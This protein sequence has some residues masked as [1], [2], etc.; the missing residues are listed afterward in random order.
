MGTR[1]LGTLRRS[2]HAASTAAGEAPASLPEPAPG[3]SWRAWLATGARPARIDRRRA[4]GMD[5]RVK[6]VLL[7]GPSGAVDFPSAMARQTVD[8]AMSELPSEH[9]Q[10]IKLAYVAGLTNREI[11]MRLGLTVGGVRRR[12]RQGL[13]MIGRYVE[14]GRAA[15]RRAVHGLAWWLSGR[16]LDQLIQRS[17]GP[18]LDQVLQA[19]LVAVMTVAATAI[20]MTHHASPAPVPHLHK[21]PRVAAV[22][23]SSHL[24][25]S[26]QD[27]TLAAAP[28]PQV[29]AAPVANVVQQ[30]TSA[31]IAN[32]VQQA[33]SVA[34]VPI[35]VQLPEL[36]PMRLPAAPSL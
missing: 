33:T 2:N 27:T 9:R 28:A 8:E 30:A 24:V 13:E 15:G 5:D 21:T 14:D 35:N 18:S 11:A 20:V 12:L 3:T 17:N 26:T 29:D 10:V 19:G 6:N 34:A 7:G 31:P 1:W 32:L 16:H 23:S 22:G 4:R 36:L 25:P